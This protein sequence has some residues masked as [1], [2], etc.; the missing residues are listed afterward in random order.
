[1]TAGQTAIACGSGGRRGR[2]ARGRARVRADRGPVTGAPRP[3]HGASRR[4]R[5]RSPSRL[6]QERSAPRT[7]PRARQRPRP[8]TQLR[9]GHVAEERDQ[10]GPELLAA[11][12]LRLEKR[13]P[14]DRG[15]PR[16]RG[17]RLHRRAL[18]GRR[19]RSEREGRPAGRT[20]R[21]LGR[22][23]RQHR[24]DPERAAVEGL[25]HHR[26]SG[27][28]CHRREPQC[29]DRVRELAGR[30]GRRLAGVEL[31][32]ELDDDRAVGL[33]PEVARQQA[34]GSGQCVA[35]SPLTKGRTTRPGA[36]ST[37]SSTRCP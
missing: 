16:A 17:R 35:S 36:S 7:A 10:C 5:R 22:G 8:G 1:M 12:R 25:E 4:R 34:A 13:A 26:P 20:P 11:E 6:R 32:P 9:I 30:V 33:A 29:A 14:S 24:L 37:A 27:D 23:D 3:L 15:R 19:P 21:W 2:G 31:A 28:G 18:R